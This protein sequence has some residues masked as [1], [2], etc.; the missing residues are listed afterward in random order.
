L[1]QKARRANR[2]A[3]STTV[4]AF[5]WRRSGYLL[6]MPH[7]E[8]DPPDDHRAL[9]EAEREEAEVEEEREEEAVH[10]TDRRAKEFEA[11]KEAPG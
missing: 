8:P 6:T 11:E 1:C 7:H 5:R 3:Q 9:F 2:L 10:R 4:V